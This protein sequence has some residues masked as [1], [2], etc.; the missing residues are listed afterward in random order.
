MRGSCAS[1]P[2]PKSLLFPEN[3]FLTTGRARDELTKPISRCL[4]WQSQSQIYLA[5]R[6]GILFGTG[7]ISGTAL[8]YWR[9]PPSR[10]YFC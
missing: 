3:N 9:L 4:S 2:K 10:Q 5:W 8:T 7:S 6:F 1:F